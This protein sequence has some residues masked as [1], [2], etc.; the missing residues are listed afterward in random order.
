MVLRTHHPKIH[1]LKSCPLHV[2]DGN[3]RRLLGLDEM[4]RV[5]PS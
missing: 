1:L 3:F 5:E 4:L 2:G